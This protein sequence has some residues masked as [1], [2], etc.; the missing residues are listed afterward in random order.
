MLLD[1][2]TTTPANA[3]VP[4]HDAKCCTAHLPED[5]VS[6]ACYGKSRCYAP[7]A[8]LAKAAPQKE[9]SKLLPHNLPCEISFI[10]DIVSWALGKGGTSSHLPHTSHAS[11]LQQKRVAAMAVSTLHFCWHTSKHRGLRQSEGS[12]M[13][14][15]GLDVCCCCLLLALHILLN[16]LNSGVHSCG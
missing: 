14:T 15:D 1:S 2:M 4:C 13:W 10:C 11:G 5:Q 6:M 7:A 8:S 9:F 16:L 3:R 12:E